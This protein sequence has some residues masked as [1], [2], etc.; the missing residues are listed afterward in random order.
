[1]FFFPTK[2]KSLL[3]FCMKYT[4]VFV[5]IQAMPTILQL[6]AAFITLNAISDRL[7]NRAVMFVLT[8]VPMLVLN[9]VLMRVLIVTAVRKL[10][11][12]PVPASRVIG[13]RACP[14]AAS[15]EKRD[16]FLPLLPRAALAE[17]VALFRRGV[18]A[19]QSIPPWRCVRP[20]AHHRIAAPVAVFHGWMADVANAP[21]PFRLALLG[22]PAA[23]QK[24]GGGIV[25]R[26][27]Q[28]VAADE[29]LAAAR[30]RVVAGGAFFAGGKL[31][32]PTCCAVN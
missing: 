18:L 32:L 9:A 10:A 7:L 29:A 26:H 1:M 14:L 27:A 3:H 8:A 22:P 12:P 25:R 31:V 20:S 2:H 30:A 19:Q 16:V 4:D 24:S 6:A 13:L 11:K 17:S 15:R 21:R 23:Q 5:A 28:M